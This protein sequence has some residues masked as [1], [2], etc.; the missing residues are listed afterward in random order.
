LGGKRTEQYALILR[1]SCY[2]T[3]A[4]RPVDARRH[5][6]VHFAADVHVLVLL[7]K[8]RQVLA[9]NHFEILLSRLNNQRARRQT[10]ASV[11]LITNENARL[12]QLRVL[13]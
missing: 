5:D 10:G 12:N 3:Q 13:T 7:H 2:L 4:S 6:L 11:K 1:E 9:D 8:R